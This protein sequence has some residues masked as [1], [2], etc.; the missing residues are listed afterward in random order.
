MNVGMDIGYSR[1]KV[2]GDRA[3]ADFASVTG[4]P[5]RARFSLNGADKGIHLVCPRPVLVG[6]LA[7]IQSRHIERR[8]DRG[9]IESEAYHDLL[10]AALTELTTATH[11]DLTIVSGLPVQFYERDKGTL[12]GLLAGE[13][14]VQREDRRAQTFTVSQARVIPQGFGALLSVCLNDRG[15]IVRPDLANGRVG[16]IDVGGKT[17]NLLSVNRLSEVSRETASVNAGAWDVAR[18]VQRWL[19][20]QC[21]DLELRDHELI[22]AI[23]VR[24]V[25]Y[26]GDPVDLGAVIDGAIAPLADQVIASA[27]QLWNGAAGLDVI[28]VA[29]GGAHL[30]GPAIQRHFRHAQVIE[31]DPVYANALGYWR[32]SQRLTR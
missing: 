31:G 10:L 7:V 1:T 23:R 21:P 18:A 22:D 20:G 8:E 28:F 25:R 9:W 2:I 6:D 27:G 15:D 4:T 14:K 3:R 29:G 12:A 13:H 19:D 11:V 32:F 24:K 17:T 5:D 26:F 30:V 16:L